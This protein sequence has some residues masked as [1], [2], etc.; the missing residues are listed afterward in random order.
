[1]TSHDPLYGSDG[2]KKL[3]EGITQEDQERARKIASLESFHILGLLPIECWNGE[4]QRS[5]HPY[6]RNIIGCQTGSGL[7]QWEDEYGQ[8][9]SSPAQTR[10]NHY[11]PEIYDDGSIRWYQSKC[12]QYDRWEG[13]KCTYNEFSKVWSVVSSK[14]SKSFR[15]MTTNC[16]HTS[17]YVSVGECICIDA[18]DDDVDDKMMW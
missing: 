7:A 18:I 9:S 14:D 10:W 6:K 11:R 12:H 2:H 15:Q 3:M 8:I 1:M 17:L 13:G 16:S 5:S 4:P